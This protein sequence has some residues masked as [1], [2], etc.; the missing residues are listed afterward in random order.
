MMPESLRWRISLLV[1]GMLA[2]VIAVISAVAY[3][4]QE[5]SMR[6]DTDRSLRVVAGSILSEVD[7]PWH[8]GRLH[9]QMRS[10]LG[11]RRGQWR[12]ACRV[13]LDGNAAELLLSHEADSSMARWLRQVPDQYRPANDAS[14]YFYADPGGG[15]RYRFLW[16]RNVTK[17]GVVNVVAGL[18]CSQAQH[19]MGEFLRMLVVLGGCTTV[20]SAVFVTLIIFWASRP[21]K[22]VA[23]R[24]SGITP[25]NLAAEDLSD[26][27]VPTELRPFLAALR[28]M[29]L[30]LD[31]VFQQQRRFTADAAHELRTPLA[32][33]KSTL[34]AARLKQGAGRIDSQTMEEVVGDIDRME[35]LVNQLLD[36]SRLDEK[37]EPPLDEPVA[38]NE[39]LE[40]L[41]AQYEPMAVASHGRVTL[42]PMP[43]LQVR[44]NE[45]QLSQLFSN[46][47]ENALKHGPQGREVTIGLA[48]ED[49]MCVA[50]VHDEGGAIAPEDLPRL[51]DRFYRAD[52][53]RTRATGGTGL[54]LAIAR[55]IADRH[56]GRIDVTS[57]SREGTTFAVRLPLLRS[58]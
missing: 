58:A 6:R 3:F 22:L 46:L 21:L 2:I 40:R 45:P 13:W 38:V 20:I 50:R 12:V 9:E 53:S 17:R 8:T 23:L 28:D 41:A 26:V 1:A 57:N 35:R 42:E 24:L 14:T 5:E 39:L 30:R 18:T 56:G 55:E 52:R 32:L 37:H 54:G 11:V 27:D 29:M 34:Q 36:L 15:E 44:G 10:I 49:G 4:D 16:F 25:A 19:E 7:E 48:G 47:L 43:R 33:A 31:K 51:F